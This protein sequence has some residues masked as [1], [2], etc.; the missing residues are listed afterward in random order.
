MKIL[1]LRVSGL[2]RFKDVL[3]VDFWAQQRVEPKKSENLY[4]LFSNIY[5]NNAVSF[6]GIN[7]SGKTTNL[8]VISF[9][10]NLLNN[11]SINSMD[12]NDILEGMEIDGSVEFDTYFHHGHQLYRLYTLIKKEIDGKEGSEKYVIG[13]ERI[14][15]KD[16]KKIKTKKGLFEF[17]NADLYMERDNDEAYLME[18]VSIMVAFHKKSESK[19]FMRDMSQWVNFNV[20]NIMGEFPKELLAFLDPSIESIRFDIKKEKVAIALKFKGK[21]ELILDS[22][23]LLDHYLSSGT[24]KGM[25]IFMSAIFAF[26][27][28]GYL[29]VDELENHFNREIMATLLRFFMDDKVN[30]R[31]A[32][33]IFSTHYS[34]FLDEFERNDAIYITT[35]KGGITAENLANILKR[36]DMKKSEAFQ[37]GHLMDTVPAYESYMDLKKAIMK[38]IKED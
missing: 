1:K 16:E 33:L 37:S 25:G 24:I 9:V 15:S 21:K 31:G 3:E 8:K 6:V 26:M 11:K 18:D 22:P 30:K 27:E 5:T 13:K 17:E 19:I 14:W 4:C 36:N 10:L 38:Q 23:I 34:E 7:A 32:T 28:G 29:I 35:N 12:N 20:L 2:P